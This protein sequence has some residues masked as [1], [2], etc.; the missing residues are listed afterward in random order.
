MSTLLEQVKQGGGFTMTPQ[1]ALLNVNFGYQVGTELLHTVRVDDLTNGS[2]VELVEELLKKINN[3]E[4]LGA[5]LAGDRVILD[6]SV[7]ITDYRLAMLKAE[8][9]QQMSIYDWCNRD[10]IWL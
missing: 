2:F 3:G 1:G 4:Y 10:C 9:N 7:H 5:W 8:A 6:K